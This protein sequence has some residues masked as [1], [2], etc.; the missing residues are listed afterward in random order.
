MELLHTSNCVLGIG[1]T[2]WHDLLPEDDTRVRDI[3]NGTNTN[4]PTRSVRSESVREL[5]Q[6]NKIKAFSNTT[7]C[8]R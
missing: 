1:G 5:P 6:P 2:D 8:F 4:Y 7:Q 3:V